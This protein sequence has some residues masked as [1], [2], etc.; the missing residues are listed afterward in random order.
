MFL[1]YLH[2]SDTASYYLF[3]FKCYSFLKIINDFEKVPSVSREIFGK[4]FPEPKRHE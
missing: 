1:L 4:K 2:T 3:I